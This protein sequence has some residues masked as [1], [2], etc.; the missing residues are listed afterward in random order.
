MSDHSRIEW[1]DATWNPVRGCTKV[2]P[3]CAHCYAE[4]FAERFRD[5]PGHPYEQGFDLRL[6]PEKLDEPLRWA[7]PRRIFVNSMSDL[8]HDGVPDAYIV[9]IARVMQAA[10]WHTFQ[11]LTKRAERLRDLLRANLAFAAGLTHIWWGVSVENRQHGVPRIA[12]LRAAP[13]ARRFLS[14]EPLLEDLGRIDLNGI[15]WVIVGGESG[16]GARP[17]SPAWARSLR[18]QCEAANIPFF[19]K[20][21]G[22]PIKKQTGRLLDGRT[23]DTVPPQHR[24]LAPL[25]RVRLRLLYNCTEPPDKPQEERPVSE[26][27]VSEAEL[28]VGREQSLIKHFILSRYLER[29]AHIVGTFWKTITYVDCFSGPWNVRSEAQKDSSFAVALREL[30]KARATLRDDGKD[31]NIR[32]LFIEKDAAAHGRLAEFAASVK[33]A[34]VETIN[35]PFIDALPRVLRFIE[36][37]GRQA[38]P[39]LFIDPK[40]WS[41]LDLDAIRP[42]LKVQPGEVLI[43]FMT[44]FVR[45]FIESDNAQTAESI[46]RFFGCPGVKQ[47]VQAINDKEEREDELFLAYARQVRKIGCYRYSCAAIVLRPLEE[48]SFFHLIYATRSRRGVEVFKEAE[49]KAM[50]L[51]AEVRAEAHQRRRISETGEPELF[52]ACDMAASQKITRLRERYLNLARRE[53]EDKLQSNPSVAYDDLWD[54]AMAWPLVWDC[55]VKAWLADWRQRGVVDVLGLSPRQRVPKMGADVRLAWKHSGVQLALFG[56]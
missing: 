9:A 35:S 43:N 39:F 23:H 1:T 27:D 47:R 19:F 21:W 49:K 55:D 7:A 25:R 34:H 12:H 22:G 14:I 11:V 41:G 42:L 32:C 16:P 36:D 15:S 40:G 29:F 37:G 5:V 6:V 33:D 52:R 51:M 17:M 31:L 4:A 3:G 8:F 13:A 26:A 50:P 53:A 18:D 24:Q 45:R 30:R 38:F 10:Y 44:E 28:Y 20:Q 2:S 46:D 56:S 54:A 48:R